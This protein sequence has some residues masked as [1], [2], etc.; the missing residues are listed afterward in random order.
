M[1]IGPAS[2]RFLLA[3]PAHLVA[4]GL[5]AA[6]APALLAWDA[7]LWLLMTGFV[8]ETILGFLLHLAPG[9]LGRPIG[10]ARGHTGTFVVAEAAVLAGTWGLSAAAPAGA[11]TGLELAG[12]VLWLVAASMLVASV[13]GTPTPRPTA[14]GRELGPAP[15]PADRAVEP[16]LVASLTWLLAAAGLWGLAAVEPGPGLGWF[17]AGVHL[18]LV[19]HAATL[20][21]A[22]GLRL[23][24]RALGTDPPEALVRG[25]V[26]AAALGPGALALG[27]LG[28]SL[29]GIRAVALFALPEAFAGAAFGLAVVLVALRARTPKPT[30][31][32]FVVSTAALAVGGL[33]GLAMAAGPDLGGLTFHADVMLLG[34]LGTMIVAMV[35]SMLAPFQRVG[36]RWTVVALAAQTALLAA[37]VAGLAA[38]PEAAPAWGNLSRAAGGVSVAVVGALWIAGVVP[39][40]Y[41]PGRPGSGRA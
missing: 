9:L 7:G 39:V 8:G 5:V 1:P 37:G 29:W 26:P 25:L 24:P 15:R 33:A 28:T 20:V 22:V 36:H 41:P 21:F 4:W 38:A 11:A 18:F 6:A 16:L 34:F 13:R 10:A 30:R 2:R 17:V 31:G 27:M 32:A 19:G 23:L 40:L 12:A 14:P 35:A 3:A